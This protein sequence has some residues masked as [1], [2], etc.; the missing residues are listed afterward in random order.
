M[1]HWIHKTCLKLNI[2]DLFVLP[3]VSLDKNRAWCPR[4][5]C[6]TICHVCDPPDPNP[7]KPGPLEAVA[8]HC[9]SCAKEF[10]SLCSSNWHP[11]KTCQQNGQELVQKSREGNGSN[12]GGVGGADFMI[13]FDKFEGEIKP[14]PMCRI[15]IERDQGCAQMMCRKCKHVFCWFC[16]TS[17]DVSLLFDPLGTTKQL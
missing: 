9:P 15:P 11:G 1:G 4:A 6:D 16:L 2:T 7:S 14:C 17:L 3:E 10:C 12:D 5:D 13:N 8:V